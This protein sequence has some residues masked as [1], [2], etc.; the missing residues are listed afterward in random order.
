M[1]AHQKN[2][3]P[4]EL[5]NKALQSRG[6][7]FL[8]IRL[9][10]IQPDFVNHAIVSAPSVSTIVFGGES[11]KIINR[12]DVYF[13]SDGSAYSKKGERLAEFDLN[14]AAYGETE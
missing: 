8:N 12:I 4:W 11:H 6:M 3:Y 1:A 14:L 9:N 2:Y 10:R 13:R 5:W 7:Y